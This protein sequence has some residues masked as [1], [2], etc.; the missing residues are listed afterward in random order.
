MT[1]DLLS[2]AKDNRLKRSTALREYE[3]V[4]KA[5]DRLQG[6]SDNTEVMIRYYDGTFNPTVQE[7]RMMLTLMRDRL[8]REIKK[9]DDEFNDM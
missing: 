6:H 2:K 5:I 4:N 3:K 7:F 8:D 1:E 9:L